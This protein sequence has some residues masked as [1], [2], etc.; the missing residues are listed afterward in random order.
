[1]IAIT[2]YQLKKRNS[3]RNRVVIIFLVTLVA[4][5]F[6]MWGR[7]V[8]SG[9]TKT[10]I[11]QNVA[12]VK[13]IAQLASLEVSGSTQIKIS[14]K[15]DEGSTWE[16]FK[17]YF[18]ENTLLLTVPY[19]AKYGV[20]MRNQKMKI[21]SKGGIVTIYLPAVKLMSMQ[22]RLD[23]MESMQQ[24]G[25]LNTVTLADV[26]KAQ[27]QMYSAA[28]STLENHKAYKKL[29]EDNIKNT[30]S[31]YFEPMGYKVNLQFDN[32]ASASLL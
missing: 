6:F 32:S 7:K 13:E 23:K 1:M 11:V 22:L 20:D 24:T 17:N 28:I 25:I 12:I 9:K 29:S 15:G 3:M 10:D 21:D 5:A 19:E 4:F 27:K 30:L 16:K 8:G 31:R 2:L 14:N 26:T 18:T